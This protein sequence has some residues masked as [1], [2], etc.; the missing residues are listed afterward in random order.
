MESAAPRSQVDSRAPAA[1]SGGRLAASGSVRQQTRAGGNDLVEQALCLGG[2]AGAQE[3]ARQR[4]FLV[5]ALDLVEPGLLRGF[6]AHGAEVA[7]VA[8]CR[9]P[10]RGSELRR[11]RRIELAGL[12]LRLRE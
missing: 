5:G 7:R 2:I 3:R 1:R 4:H 8:L 9:L 12:L 11:Q 10:L 6:L